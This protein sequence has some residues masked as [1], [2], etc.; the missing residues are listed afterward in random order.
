MHSRAIF[1]T[2]AMGALSAAGVAQ[3]ARACGG[4]FH[5]PAPPMPIKQT[6]TVVTDH[7]MI[8][9]ITQQETTLYD[10]IQYSG[11][12]STFAWVLPIRGTVTIGLSSKSLFDALEQVTQTDVIAPPQPICPASSCVCYQG[13]S[14][15]PGGVLSTTGGNSTTGGGGSPAPPPVTVIAEQTVGPFETVQLQSTDPNALDAWLSANGY[16]IPADVQPIIAAYVSDGFDFLALKLAPGQ[17]V[18]A[19]RPVRVSTPGAGLSLP[20]RMV[21]AGTGSKVGITLWVVADGRYEPHNAQFFTIAPSEVTWDWAASSSD[22]SA[23]RDSKEASFNYVA[24]QVESSVSIS[25]GQVRNAL[26]SY[27]FDYQP[28]PPP[29]G[30]D[31]GGGESASQ[32]EM[33]DLLVLYPRAFPN[34]LSPPDRV[35][36]L[37][38][39]LARAALAADL[40]LQASA[41]Q[42]VMANVYQLTNSL[43]PPPCIPPPGCTCGNNG[44]SNSGLSNNGLAAPTQ[45][46]GC[47][48]STNPPGAT[49]VGF[50]AAG[51]LAIALLRGRRRR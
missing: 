26:L 37:R 23:V 24:W 5:E 8:F 15:S 32:A 2:A 49:A 43:N 48:A 38:A 29:D 51:L 20:L 42:G 4:C 21:A 7:R 46:S 50:G 45:S 17:G 1:L 35:T 39:D 36:R 40:V 27:A 18:Q 47:A 12:P 19:M 10:E 34:A 25:E 3:D 44:P 31:G 33:D 11:S 22:Y 41:D 14:S 16:A 6:E 9:R 13:A 28:V 30:G